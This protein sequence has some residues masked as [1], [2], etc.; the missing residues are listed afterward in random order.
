MTERI[1]T[2]VRH[3]RKGDVLCGSGFVVTHNP[4]QKVGI[5]S[6]T[7]LVEGFYPGGKNR[8]FLW[9]ASTTVTVDRGL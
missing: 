6:G 3:I 1:A 7:L 4:Y 8:I 5:A 2:T 9:K